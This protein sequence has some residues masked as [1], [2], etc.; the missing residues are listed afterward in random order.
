MRR[1]LIVFL[2]IP[3]IAYGDYSGRSSDRTS[4]YTVYDESIKLVNSEDKTVTF[5]S[6]TESLKKIHKSIYVDQYLYNC[7]T[8]YLSFRAEEKYD[9]SYP[10]WTAPDSIGRRKGEY[11]CLY[12]TELSIERKISAVYPDW[13]QIAKSRKFSSWL[14][15]L[16]TD[17][18]KFILD[19]EDADIVI[20]SL[21]NFKKWEHELSNRS[22]GTSKAEYK[23]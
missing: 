19:S 12:I 1:L 5:Y 4:E 22:N 18:K 9:F 15:T 3:V 21:D 13:R 17:M 11:A 2:F 6:R 23:F 10:E 20:K 16:P 14:N 8:K 7:N